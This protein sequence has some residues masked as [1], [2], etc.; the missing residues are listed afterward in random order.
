MPLHLLPA[1]AQLQPPV[2]L[3]R[4]PRLEHQRL[5]VLVQLLVLLLVLLQRLVLVLEL[6]VPR[7]VL[8]QRPL[9]R[10]LQALQQSLLTQVM[11]QLVL[12]RLPELPVLLPAQVW[13]L[14]QALQHLA[15]LPFLL[16]RLLG[17]LVVALYWQRLH[18]AIWFVRQTCRCPLVLCLDSHHQ[19]LR[20]ATTTVVWLGKH[21][22]L[23]LPWSTACIRLC[24]ISNVTVG[25]CVSVCACECVQYV[26]A[27]AQAT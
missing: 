17:W 1:Q 27:I 2:Q 14:V 24:E 10:F 5:L 20:F 21:A 18:V 4:P 6:L 9:E 25:T 13:R 8:R 11:V 3:L 26:R 16:A 12:V 23:G 15:R 22:S 19:H 7:P